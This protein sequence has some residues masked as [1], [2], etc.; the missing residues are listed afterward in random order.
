MRDHMTRSWVVLLAL[1][2]GGGSALAQVDDPSPADPVLLQEA[3]LSGTPDFE[4]ELELNLNPPEWMGLSFRASVQRGGGPVDVAR[5]KAIDDFGGARPPLTV[6]LEY[7]ER[8]YEAFGV[9][10]VSDY[11]VFRISL[12]VYF[13]DFEGKGLLTV[14]DG[15]VPA[16]QQVV[17]VEGDFFGFRLE[18]FFPTIRA[19]TGGLEVA[20]GPALSAGMHLSEPESPREAPLEVKDDIPELIG[21]IGPRLSVRLQ[22]NGFYLSAEAEAAYLFSSTRGLM[23]EVSLGGGVRF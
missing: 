13:G 10:L 1:L 23:E 14:D 21:T 2:A 9:G 20:L 7:D 5:G 8:E 16:T 19:R 12:D 11:N 15:I 4:E 22:L 18:V 6:T 3:E 17:D